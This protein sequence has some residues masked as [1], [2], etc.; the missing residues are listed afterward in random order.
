MSILESVLLGVLQGVAEFLP[1]SSSGHLALAQNLLGLEDVPILFDVFLH[2]ATLCAVVLFFRKKIWRLLCAFAKLIKRL[3]VR[4][5][6]TTEDK[7]L[8]QYIL[9]VIIATVFTGIIG[10]FVEKKLKNIPIKVVCVGF[11][12]TSVLLIL[13]SVLEKKQ[14]NKK[15]LDA[16]TWKQAILIGIAQGIGTL[17]GVSRSGSTISGALLCNVTREVAGEFSFIASIP[18]ILGAFLLELKDLGEVKE[19]IGYLP[20]AVGGVTAFVCGIVSLALLMKIV[21]KGKLSWFALYLIPVAVLGLIF[22]K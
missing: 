19:S 21:K 17:P 20:L 1:I 3:F 5:N 8:Q 4:N 13:S 9:G 2:I 14:S 10:I 16:P 15:T 22:L 12:F 18:A 11:I 7:N 6:E